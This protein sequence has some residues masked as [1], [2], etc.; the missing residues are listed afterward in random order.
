MYHSHVGVPSRPD[1]KIAP[2]AVS[3]R[4]LTPG[5]NHLLKHLAA[6]RRRRHD[7]WGKRELEQAA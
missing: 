7:Q 4:A 1:G 3:S 5:Q 6:K 2:E